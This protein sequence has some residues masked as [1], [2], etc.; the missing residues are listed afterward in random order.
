MIDEGSWGSRGGVLSVLD[1]L[2]SGVFTEQKAA[3]VRAHITEVSEP[4]A[5]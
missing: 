5:G 1:L 3:A 2:A 4:V